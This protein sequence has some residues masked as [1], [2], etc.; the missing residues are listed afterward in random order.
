MPISASSFDEEIETW[1][2]ILRVPAVA[3]KRIRLI[4]EVLYHALE[5][6]ANAVEYSDIQT[7][8]QICKEAADIWTR[9]I[10]DYAPFNIATQLQKY[11]EDALAMLK[12]LET[13]D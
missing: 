8:V 7:S 1:L 10:Y 2:E 5:S 12:V 4:V 13:A 3:E 9:L 6:K 11:R